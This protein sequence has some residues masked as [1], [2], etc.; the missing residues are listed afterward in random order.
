M[1][2]V[3]VI[4]FTFISLNCY[5]KDSNFILDGKWYGT[6]PVRDGSVIYNFTINNNIYIK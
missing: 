4:F 6:L 2:E 5:G 1:N 3:L